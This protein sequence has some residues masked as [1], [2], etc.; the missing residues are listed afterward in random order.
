[1]GLTEKNVEDYLKAKVE[2]AG[3]MYIKIP[4]VYASGIP[5]RLILMPGGKAAFAELKRPQ[6]GR[7]SPLQRD[8][9]LPKLASLGFIAQRVKNYEE[10]DELIGR[11]L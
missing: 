8:Y 6:G 1:M 7:L 3:G 9:W 2:D 4:A 10:A 11:L 5:D